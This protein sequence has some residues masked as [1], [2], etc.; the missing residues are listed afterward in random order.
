MEGFWASALRFWWVRCAAG[1]LERGGT[2]DYVAFVANWEREDGVSRVF[3]GVR[4]FEVLHTC[5]N[6]LCTMSKEGGEQDRAGR[7]VD[8][9]K[10]LHR[11]PPFLPKFPVWAGLRRF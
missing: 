8:V 3:E 1:G 4:A 11:E 6:V 10:K 9:R 2:R 5:K 7:M